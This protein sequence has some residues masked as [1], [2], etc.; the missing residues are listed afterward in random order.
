MDRQ[1]FLTKAAAFNRQPLELEGFGTVFVREISGL[2][3]QEQSRASAA[4]DADDLL[5]TA[6]LAVRVLC[7]ENG[8]PMLT[9]ADIPAMRMVPL[10][11]LRAIADAAARLSA[12]TTPA[13]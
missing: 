10:R 6:A 4:K 7:D 2:E 1:T 3:A 9:D 11:V 8:Q 5:N 13:A 12:G